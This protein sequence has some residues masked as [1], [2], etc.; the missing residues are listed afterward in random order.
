[1]A[2]DMIM[3]VFL[4]GKYVQTAAKTVVVHRKN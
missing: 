3:L 4:L 2:I 1:M